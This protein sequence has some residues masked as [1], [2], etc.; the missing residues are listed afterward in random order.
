M[1]VWT[2]KPGG[3]VVPG[4]LVG[5][6]LQPDHGA[7]ALRGPDGQLEHDLA[8]DRAPEHH[9]PLEAKRLAEGDDQLD[10][11]GR[12]QAVLLVL[13][14]RGRQRL[15]V[16]GHVEGEDAPVLRQCGVC[17]QMPVLPSVRAGGVETH[18]RP[19]LARLLEVDAVRAFAEGEMD[20]PPDDR[21][22]HSDQPATCARRGAARTSFTY[23]RCAMRGQ[24]SPST[25]ATPSFFIAKRSW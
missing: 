19:A 5:G 8:P 20:V 11:G 10:V 17:Q 15:P 22:E 12:G 1:H 25:R 7:E 23:L 14:A 18:E 9:R 6:G 4:R 13:P 21:L 3:V 2:M 24:R 16:P